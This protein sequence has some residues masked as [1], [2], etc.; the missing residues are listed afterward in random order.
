MSTAEAVSVGYAAALHAYYY[1]GGQIKV[2]HLLQSMLGSALK[3]TSEDRKK[4]EHYFSHIVRYKKGTLWQDC[5]NTY[6]RL[7]DG[8]LK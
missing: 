1:Q 5:Y 4:L 6:R 7:F 2:E 8:S 3:G